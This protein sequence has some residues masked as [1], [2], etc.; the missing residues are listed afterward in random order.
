VAFY[1][2]LGNNSSL[3]GT[4]ISTGAFPNLKSIKFSMKS[5]P[6]TPNAAT[7]PLISQYFSLIFGNAYGG[8]G[9]TSAEMDAIY[10]M[11]GTRLVGIF[12][13]GIKRLDV[14][15]F[16]ASAT[17]ASLTARTY[18]AGQGWIVN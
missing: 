15:W 14:Q 18:L 10:N 7:F 12:P 16:N 2:I 4:G 3:D 5:K 17:A 1:R 9:W 8:E 11:L 13:V 6:F